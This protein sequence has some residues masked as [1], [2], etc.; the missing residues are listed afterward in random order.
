MGAFLREV[1]ALGKFAFSA[2]ELFNKP[3]TLQFEIVATT[4]HCRLYGLILGGQPLLKIVAEQLREAVVNT[5]LKL[6]GQINF[7]QPVLAV[8]V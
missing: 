6:V 5:P 2:P 4:N 1:P 3:T 8:L 7:Q